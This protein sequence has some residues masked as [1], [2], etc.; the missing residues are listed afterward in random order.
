MKFPAYLAL[1]VVKEIGWVVAFP[2][3]LVAYVCVMPLVVAKN[4]L[5]EHKKKWGR[6]YNIG[7]DK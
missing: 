5:D 1:Q 6:E 7:G 4:W 2:F 3:M